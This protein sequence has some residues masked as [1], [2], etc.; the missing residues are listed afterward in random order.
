MAVDRRAR[1]IFTWTSEHR[2]P[3]TTSK[4]VSVR[5]REMT[6]PIL[7]RLVA[8][9]VRVLLGR[10]LLCQVAFVVRSNSPHVVDIFIVVL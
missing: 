5:Q 2:V 7:Q 6:Y 4:H 9:A 10:F 8:S 3:T 1:I